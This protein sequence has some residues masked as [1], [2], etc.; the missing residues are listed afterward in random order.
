M[1]FTILRV[2]LTMILVQSSFALP[3]G[4]IIRTFPTMP[5]W[6][7]FVISI[8]TIP[9]ICYILFT[10]FLNKE[11]PEGKQPNFVQRNKK[12]IAV[13]VL[14][15]SVMSGFASLHS[16]DCDLTIDNGTI[17][18]V[19]V[20]YLDRTREYITVDIPTGGFKTITLPVGD[21]VLTINGNKKNI[22]M[23]QRGEKYIYNI[24]KI[25]NYIL[26]EIEYGDDADLPKEKHH[27]LSTEFFKVSADYLFE[28]PESI[29]GKRGSSSK[30]KVL[31]RFNNTSKQNQDQITPE[32]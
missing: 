32:N 4:G 5:T 20:E 21:N 28:A 26:A 12:S 27:F 16:L 18:S 17:K 23:G 2:I 14:L 8:L 22:K 29:I 6:L 7:I 31:Y 3:I 9:A 11:L 24:D 13:G 19:K 10:K 15:G 1:R 30:I 25:N